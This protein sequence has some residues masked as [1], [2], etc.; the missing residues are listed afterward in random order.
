MSAPCQAQNQ[1]PVD[2]AFF[3]KQVLPILQTNCLKCHG[4]EAKIK[5]GL[6]LTSRED[7]VK[8][9]DSGPAVVLEKP[10]TSRLLQAIRYQD[11]LEMP[12]KGKLADKDIAVLTRWVTAKIPWGTIIA[13]TAAP[14]TSAIAGKVTPE[15]R[16]FWAYQPVHRPPTPEVKHNSWVHNPIDAFVLARLEAKGL[17]PVGPADRTAWLRRVTYDLI[18]LPPTPEETAAYLADKSDKAD[19]RLIDRL[20]DSPHYGEKGGRHWLDLVR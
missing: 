6:R 20:L 17:T 3:D 12:P 2:A 1:P 19:E 14:S 8:G 15:G 13:K 11:G 10:D 7:I 18:G 4:A 16:A 5:G 9:G